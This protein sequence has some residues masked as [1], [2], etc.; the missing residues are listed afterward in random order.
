MLRRG[1]AL[2]L[3]LQSDGDCGGAGSDDKG[4]VIFCSSLGI[5]LEDDGSFTTLL[6]TFGNDDTSN[7][8]KK[9]QL[10]I[11]WSKNNIIC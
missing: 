5:N 2:L 8:K 3:K 10:I 4:I 7:Y 9:K 1:E 6:G 11:Y